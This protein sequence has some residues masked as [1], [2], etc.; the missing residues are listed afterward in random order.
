MPAPVSE[1]T[2]AAAHDRKATLALGRGA[3]RA[4]VNWRAKHQFTNG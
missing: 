2:A 3:T 4:P 1:D